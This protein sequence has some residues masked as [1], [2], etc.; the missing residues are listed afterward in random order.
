MVG[1]GEGPGLGVS[2]GVRVGRGVAV[3]VGVGEGPGLAVSVGVRVGRGVAVLVGVG[4]GPGL[5]VGVEV[6]V[7]GI[8]VIVGIV[9]AT[10]VGVVS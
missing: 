8:G 2:D 4:E 1:V 9:V 6:A 5:T 7:K 10:S 3:L